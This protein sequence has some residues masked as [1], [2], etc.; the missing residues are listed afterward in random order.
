LLGKA[1]SSGSSIF[2]MTQQVAMVP[3]VILKHRGIN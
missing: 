3:R 2:L 1:S